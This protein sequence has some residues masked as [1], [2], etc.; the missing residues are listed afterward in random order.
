MF[1]KHLTKL[2][3]ELETLKGSTPLIETDLNSKE[4]FVNVLET[5][6]K[7]QKAYAKNQYLNAEKKVR[8]DPRLTKYLL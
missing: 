7:R 6:I 4:F 5:R 8:Q 1:G 2:N 3:T